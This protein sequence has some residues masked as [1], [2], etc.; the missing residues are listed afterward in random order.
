MLHLQDIYIF[1]I[2]SLGGI[3]VKTCIA[4]ERGLKHDRRWMLVD[5]N[6]RFLSQREHPSMALLQTKLTGTGIHV[7]HKESSSS[8]IFI[9]FEPQTDHFRQVTIWGNEVPAQLVDYNISRWFSEQLE[10]QCDLVYM[11][12]STQRK[13]DPDYAFNHD[14]VSFAD[15]MP[16]LLISQASLDDLNNRLSAPVPMNRFRPN[17]V[18]AGGEAFQE[19]DWGEISMGSARFHGVK[20]CARCVVTTIDQKTSEKGKEPLKTLASYRS[21]NNKV[22]FGQNLVLLKGAEINVGDS[23]LP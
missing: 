23:I 11:P 5:E 1:P 15:E 10:Q 13:A 16:F 4:E 3:R 8:K 7:Y 6:G 17:L 20:P 2:K 19:D 12:E 9:P 22:L 14:S 21:Y 18:V